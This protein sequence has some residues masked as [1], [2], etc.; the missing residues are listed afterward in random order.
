MKTFEKNDI[1]E[2]VEQFVEL[3]RRGPEDRA[4]YVG[5]CPFHDDHTPS[6]TVYPSTQRFVCWVCTG[7][8]GGDVIDFYRMKDGISFQEAK[9]LATVDVPLEQAFEKYLKT[10]PSKT[11]VDLKRLFIRA[12]KL[13]DKYEF[14]QANRIIAHFMKHINNDGWLLADQIL[15]RA[16]V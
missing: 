4:Y 13:F 2:T 11:S 12:N 15:K 14:E 10:N 9:K 6:L 16:G 3:E 5:L 8:K 7:P 1:V